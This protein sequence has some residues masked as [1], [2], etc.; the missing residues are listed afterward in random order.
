[1]VKCKVNGKMEVLELTIS[2]EVVDP[3]DVET[4]QDLVVAAIRNAMEKAN[5]MM[6]SQMNQITGGLNIPGLF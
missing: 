1:M 3:D 4:L 6:S 2:P 5:D